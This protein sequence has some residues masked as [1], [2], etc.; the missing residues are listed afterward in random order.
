MTSP[1]RRL[2]AAL[3]AASFAIAIPMDFA[4]AQGATVGPAG[5]APSTT[6]PSNS[7]GTPAGGTGVISTT[8]VGPSG[9]APAPMAG[10]PM[11]S[12]GDTVSPPP[13]R[14][15]ARRPVRR[16]RP[17]TQGTQSDNNLNTP[18]PAAR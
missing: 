12:T 7:Q 4:F 10:A 17:T 13:R 15:R 14:R 11:A 9:I 1:F 6:A 2:S 3:V 18:I 8:R 5:G 16:P